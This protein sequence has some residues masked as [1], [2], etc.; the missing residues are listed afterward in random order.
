MKYFFAVILS[1]FI[2]AGYSQ[3]I[4]D[5]F[6]EWIA[7]HIYQ[8]LVD[9]DRLAEDKEWMSQMYG[10]LNSTR[11]DTMS[12]DH[13]KAYLINAYNTLV[14]TSIVENL[15][16]SSVQDIKGFFTNKHNLGGKLFSLDE[17]EKKLLNPSADPRLHLALVCGAISCPPLHPQAFRG[18]TLNEELDAAVRASLYNSRTLKAS[19]EEQKL[20]LSQI[21]R[22]YAS[23][24]GP[25]KKW[26]AHYFPDD[27]FT[28]YSVSY[29]PYNW[30]LNHPE[31]LSE[32]LVSGGNRDE[33][34]RYYASN[35]YGSGEYEIMIFNNYFRE[36]LERKTRNDFF[37]SFTRLTYGINKRLNLIMEI[38]IRSVS[39]GDTERLAFFDALKFSRE[40]ESIENGAQITFRNAGIS[41][42][43]P[44]IKFQPF[45]DLA[46]LTF[47]TGVA[48]P[49]QFDGQGG[50]LD[51]GSPSL[52]HDVF[53]DQD[54]GAKSSLFFQLGVWMENIGG[55]FFRKFDGYY[56]FSTPMT[57]IYQY[58]P[59]Q[60]TT[61][62]ALVN[63]APQWGYS[64]T[65]NG[66]SIEAIAD[67]YSQ[68]GAGIKQFVSRKWQFEILVS[69]FHTSRF[70]SRAA[71]YNFAVRYYN[72]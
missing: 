17:I 66:A 11:F 49:T 56:Q 41:A 44:R 10:V 71:T 12:P 69:S 68:Y 34:L 26:L 27:I 62:F 32:N 9:Y 15:P 57:F 60:T 14:I 40:G 43:I 33:D 64:V 51:W 8:G 55:S 65:N 45:K 52:F 48:I 46:T 20:Y 63:A 37:T 35:L 42:L 4:E 5:Y 18:Q 70:Q 54:I 30:I 7:P 13:Q 59:N 6:D 53:Y 24:F 2:T 19:G 21:F 23:D 1:L 58:F 31:F 22:W 67:S 29:M 16:A 3:S 25:V 72:W 61:L 39:F 47:Q 28:N 38:R 36:I 50:F